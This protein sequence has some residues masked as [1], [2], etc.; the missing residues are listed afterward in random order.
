MPKIIKPDRSQSPMFGVKKQPSYKMRIYRGKGNV[1]E[2]TYR[3]ME[4]MEQFQRYYK[5]K[6]LRTRRI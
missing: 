1:Y 3:S 2:R 4:K 5:N 6:G